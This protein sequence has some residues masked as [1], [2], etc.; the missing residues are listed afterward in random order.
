MQSEFYR[1]YMRSE[2]WQRKKQQRLEI[3]NHA[4]C[5]CGRPESKTRNG[6]QIHHISYRR[7]GNENVYED[8]CSLCPA[9][10]LKI[11]RFYNR[12]RQEVRA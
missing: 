11:H 8:I 9:C 12:T 10:H 1:Q 7:L 2:E 5:M 4:C 6:L 3:D